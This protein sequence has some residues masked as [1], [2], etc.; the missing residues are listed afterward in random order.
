MATPKSKKMEAKSK[1]KT[2]VAVKPAEKAPTPVPVTTKEAKVKTRETSSDRGVLIL[3]ASLLLVGVLLLLGQFLR[4]PLADYLWPFIFIVPGVIL[5]ISAVNMESGGSGLAIVGGILTALGALFLVQSITGFW[6]SWAYAWSLVAPTSIG[7]SQWIF[8]SIKKNDLLIASGE[9]LMRIGLTIFVIGF[10]FFE[11]ILGISGF[12]L[13]QFGLPV[14][15]IVLIAIGIF[16]LVR[17]LFV[18]K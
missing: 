12:G 2:Q 18:K 3:G 11:I 5:F 13:K 16:I 17:A 9:Q 14:L 4:I 6:A 10:I 7:L 8:G 15:P 1:V